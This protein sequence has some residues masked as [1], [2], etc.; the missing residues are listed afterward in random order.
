MESDSQSI[1]MVDVDSSADPGGESLQRLMRARFAYERARAV[2]A[3]WFRLVLF[4]SACVLGGAVI[5]SSVMTDHWA[6]TLAVSG[7][8]LARALT[9]ATVEW[10]R[11]RRWMRIAEECG[12]VRMLAA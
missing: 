12:G 1:W 3:Q 8:L 6:V 9:A 11:H 7:A 2:R 4:L 5:R 10:W